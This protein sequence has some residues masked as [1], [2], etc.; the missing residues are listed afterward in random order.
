MDDYRD[1]DPEF[2]KMPFE[3]KYPTES[4]RRAF[5]M[6]L[7]NKAEP[8]TYV[9]PSFMAEDVKSTEK[10]DR[11]YIVYGILILI[12]FIAACALVTIGFLST[13]DKLLN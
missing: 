8:D 10:I 9:P 4:S 12:G 13:L 3:N 6:G 2:R 5:E 11:K 7:F 1:D